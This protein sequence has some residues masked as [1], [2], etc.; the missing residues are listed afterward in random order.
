MILTESSAIALQE[1][2]PYWPGVEDAWPCN[3]ALETYGAGLVHDP[4]NEQLKLGKR[5]AIDAMKK[6]P[7]GVEMGN[8]GVERS[9]LIMA[10]PELRA[11]LSDP[12]VIQF[13]EDLASSPAAATVKNR[14]NSEM[15][16]KVQKLIDGGVNLGISIDTL[17]MRVK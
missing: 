7:A 1:T 16:A 8:D 12:A 4:D 11:I 5:R 10:N 17:T 9:A 13:L 3:T 15:F 6:T 2:C 14:W